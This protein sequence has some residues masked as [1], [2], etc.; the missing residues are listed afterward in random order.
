M[1][2]ARVRTTRAGTAAEA[3]RLLER[4][5]GES[6]STATGT[7]DG[8]GAALHRAPAVKDIDREHP[9]AAHLVAVLVRMAEIERRRER[10]AL[11]MHERFMTDHFGDALLEEDFPAEQTEVDG[12]ALISRR[13]ASRYGRWLQQAQDL[14]GGTANNL[15]AD[16]TAAL[17]AFHRARGELDA[18]LARAVDEAGRVHRA[19]EDL[20]GI[21]EAMYQGRGFYAKLLQNVERLSEDVHGFCKAR[22]LHT[23]GCLGKAE[24]PEANGWSQRPSPSSSNGSRSNDSREEAGGSGGNH[25]DI[26]IRFAAMP[27]VADAHAAAEV[28]DHPTASRATVEAPL[29]APQFLHA[30][31]SV[32]HTAAAP[33]RPSGVAIARG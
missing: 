30:P 16:L 27:S 18:S 25:S 6:V 1:L 17:N 2:R 12:D 8:Y 24:A 11:E 20:Q 28:T 29:G 9:A 33:M 19:I 5:Q 26:H 21:V 10:L 15:L 14:V 3:T 31:P 22:Q 7:A 13:L 4:Q 23:E 32:A